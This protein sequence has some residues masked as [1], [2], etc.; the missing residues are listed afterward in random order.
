MVV[1]GVIILKKFGKQAKNSDRKTLYKF[2][3]TTELIEKGIFQYIR[4][5][6]Y[7]SLIFLSWG[8][9]LKNLTIELFFVTKLST[10]SLFLTA[11]FEEKECVIFFG[12]K[13]NDYMKR[14]KRFIPFII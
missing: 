13:Y 7:S 10:I 3:Q 2:E 12:E 1:A 5:P 8:I 14:S 4:H 9:Y 11:M 6:L